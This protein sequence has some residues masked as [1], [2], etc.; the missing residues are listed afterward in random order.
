[1]DLIERAKHNVIRELDPGLS[2]EE[3]LEQCTYTLKKLSLILGQAPYL[4]EHESEGEVKVA[5]V[6]LGLAEAMRF[7][8]VDSLKSFNSKHCTIL[9]ASLVRKMLATGL[10]SCGE[11]LKV[12]DDKRMF[13]NPQRR[14]T[15]S[16]VVLLNIIGSV[17]EDGCNLLERS[18]CVYP[19]ISKDKIPPITYEHFQKYVPH[20]VG[21]SEMPLESQL[22]FVRGAMRV[23][24]NDVQH[25]IRAD[26]I[27]SMRKCACCNR[28]EPKMR[29]CRGCRVF[30]LC[31]DE[32][33]YRFWKEGGHSKECANK[34]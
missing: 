19:L 28:L 26:W 34:K 8:D 1:M 30:A 24:P 7:K 16:F 2:D 4:H 14:I 11:Q 15:P 23:V 31:G 21:V 17:D 12:L 20:F 3:L 33:R 27:I 5:F 10:L 6:I 25:R 18:F 29:L 32:C 22:E 13:R 9:D